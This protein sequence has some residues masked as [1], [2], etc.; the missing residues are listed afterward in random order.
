M[1]RLWIA[2]ALLAAMCGAT[3]VNAYYCQQL[4]GLWWSGSSGTRRRS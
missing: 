1:K 2:V 3:L 4:A